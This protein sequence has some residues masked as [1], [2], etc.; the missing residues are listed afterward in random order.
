[1]EPS[2]D[3]L[4]TNSFIWLDFYTF[5]VLISI[6]NDLDRE[7]FLLYNYYFI[8]IVISFLKSYTRAFVCF[9]SSWWW[10][11]SLTKSLWL[12]PSSYIFFFQILSQLS[13]RFLVYI[14]LHP[15]HSFGRPPWWKAILYMYMLS[16]SSICSYFESRNMLFCNV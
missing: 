9:P 8:I 7:L 14:K 16:W 10:L 12:T 5:L 15:S 2:L 11:L 1:M 4:V 6:S 13:S 3:S